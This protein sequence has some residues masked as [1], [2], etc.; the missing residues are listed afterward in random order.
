MV[1]TIN[2]TNAVVLFLL[3]LLVIAGGILGKLSFW[4]YPGLGGFPFTPFGRSFQ[5]GDSKLFAQMSSAILT[6]ED[7]RWASIYMWSLNKRDFSCLLRLACEN[8]E[9]AHIYSRAGE[10]LASA[11]HWTSETLKWKGIYNPKYSKI[12][13]SVK[14]ASNKNSSTDCKRVYPCD[15]PFVRGNKYKIVK[16]SKGSK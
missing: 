12:L 10:L 2:L 8:P 11:A 15:A 1:L 5:D 14:L 6:Q 9:P 13:D 3:K 16:S 7:I 4:T